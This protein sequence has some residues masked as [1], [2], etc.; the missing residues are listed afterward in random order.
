MSRR[1]SAESELPAGIS[2]NRILDLGTPPWET[3]PSSNPYISGRYD[4]ESAWSGLLR[5]DLNRAYARLHIGHDTQVI[6]EEVLLG[7]TY[8]RILDGL[9]KMHRRITEEA[10]RQRVTRVKRLLL[11]DPELGLLTVVYELCG[12]WRAVGDLLHR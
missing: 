2:R 11:N 3:P 6:F 8:A 7:N 4:D 1:T 12:G 9:A 10:A 5:T